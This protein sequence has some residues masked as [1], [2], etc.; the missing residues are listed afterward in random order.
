MPKLIASWRCEQNL[1]NALCKICLVRD[2]AVVH[3]GEMFCIGSPWYANDDMKILD[4]QTH[5]W[6][7]LF[8]DIT[9]PACRRVLLDAYDGQ[10]IQFGGKTG[11]AV[12]ASGKQ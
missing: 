1:H 3:Q 12:A 5:R 7:M 11:S 8:L 2:A 9:P 10:L 4:S 6:S